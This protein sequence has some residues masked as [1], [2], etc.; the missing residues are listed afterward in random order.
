[1][2]HQ[3]SVISPSPCLRPA[4]HLNPKVAA[5]IVGWRRSCVGPEKLSLLLPPAG[6]SRL[7]EYDSL[8]YTPSKE[9]QSCQGPPTGTSGAIGWKGWNPRTRISWMMNKEGNGT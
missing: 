6:M 9:I 4:P 1:M 5:R 3:D 7:K 8:S 2:Q